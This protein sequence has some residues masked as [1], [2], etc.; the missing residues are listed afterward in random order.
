[1][2][3]LSL[4]GALCQLHSVNLGGNSNVS[5]QFGGVWNGREPPRFLLDPQS[6]C[7]CTGRPAHPSLSSRL[8]APG[9]ATSDHNLSAPL[10]PTALGQEEGS[11]CPGP[12]TLPCPTLTTLP[13]PYPTALPCPSPHC[14]NSASSRQSP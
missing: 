3:T 9:R 7:G 12:V 1:M 5:S 4:H 13:P 8:E 11:T 14:P 6:L 10:W 2:Y